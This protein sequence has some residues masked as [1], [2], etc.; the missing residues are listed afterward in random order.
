MQQVDTYMR[1]VTGKNPHKTMR[2]TMRKQ[3]EKQFKNNAKNIYTRH[4][5]I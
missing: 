5:I 1:T 4:R 3:C 2:K